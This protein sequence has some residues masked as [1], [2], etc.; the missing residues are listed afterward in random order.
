MLI[1]RRQALVNAVALVTSDAKINS[2]NAKVTNETR[3][4]FD[5]LKIGQNP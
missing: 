2:T 1:D 3:P 5:N 4:S